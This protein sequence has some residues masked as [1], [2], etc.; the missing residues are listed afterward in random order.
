MNTETWVVTTGVGEEWGMIKRLILD[1]TT[2][3]ISHADIVIAGTGQLVRVPWHYLELRRQGF[4]ISSLSCELD[5]VSAA[6]PVGTM[7]GSVAMD[8]WP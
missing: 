4:K 2:K 3:Q 8:L 7:A 5:A 1:S 6:A